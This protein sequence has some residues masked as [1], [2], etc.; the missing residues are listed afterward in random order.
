MTR[1]YGLVGQALEGTNSL[2]RLTGAPE[3]QDAHFAEVL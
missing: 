2:R 1:F 3:D